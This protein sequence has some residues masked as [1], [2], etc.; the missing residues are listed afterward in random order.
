MHIGEQKTAEFTLD[1][2]AIRLPLTWLGLQLPE[3]DQS[4]FNNKRSSVPSWV[5]DKR[6]HRQLYVLK[7]RLR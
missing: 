5:Y 4:I 3:S 6:R 2:E 1:E 7:A